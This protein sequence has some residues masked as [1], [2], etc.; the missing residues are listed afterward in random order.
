L[1]IRAFPSKV[2]NGGRRRPEP[3]SDAADRMKSGTPL[4]GGSGLG[5][6]LHLPF[7]TKTAWSIIWLYSN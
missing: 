4:T 1:S 7:L 2:T 5:E 6:D 3:P